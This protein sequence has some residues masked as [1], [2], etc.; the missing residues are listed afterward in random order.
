MSDI[1]LE[2]TAVGGIQ[3]L[4]DDAVDL[5]E[6]GKVQVTRASNV[7]FNNAVG[8]WY[9]ESAKTGY[10][11]RDDFKTRQEALA[12]EKEYY[13]PGGIGWAELTGGK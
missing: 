3:M 9:V 12:W 10:I 6:F 2:I 7:E 13:C 4:H 1:K 11:L 8:C 5:S